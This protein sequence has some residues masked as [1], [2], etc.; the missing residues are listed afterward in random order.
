M[1]KFRP[2]AAALVLLLLAGCLTGCGIVKVIPKGTEGD[3]TGVVEFDAGAE[4]AGDWAAVQEGVMG[5]AQD[6]SGLL[7]AGTENGTAYSVSFTGTV[8]EYN[9]D[10]PKGYLLVSV[11]GVSE[12][13]HIQVGNVFSGTTVRDCQ[14]LK[15]YEDFTNQTEWSQYAKTLNDEVLTNVV[16]PLGDLNTLVGATVE[17]VGCFTPASGEIVVTPVSLTVQ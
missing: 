3:Y 2:I 15:G 9:T 16:E 13:V 14:T 7:S 10:S 11:E 17:V 8:E 6:L 5:Q 1:K 12:E 4:A